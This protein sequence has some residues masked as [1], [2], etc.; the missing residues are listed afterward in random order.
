MK[1][2]FV[3][4]KCLFPFLVILVLSLSSCEKRTDRAF[5]HNDTDQG[6]TVQ[7]CFQS[8]N[9]NP[10]S[11]YVGSGEELEIPDIDHWN[12]IH[13]SNQD[14]VVFVFDDSVR[15]V[16]YYEMLLD[17]TGL[18]HEVYTPELNN[19]MS[20]FLSPNPSWTEKNTSGNKWRTDY[21]IRR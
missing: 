12:I 1:N 8:W 5:L 9:E 20:D 4:I 21:Y 17:S 18:G 6:V 11:V 7:Y 2:S 13:P 16:H 3:C 15:I 14:S 19:I 10:V